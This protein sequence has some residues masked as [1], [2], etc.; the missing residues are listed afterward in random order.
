MLELIKGAVGDAA[1]PLVFLV[2]FLAIGGG[3]L[4]ITPRLARWLDERD[5]KHKGYFDGMMTQSP[6]ENEEN[7]EEASE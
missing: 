5:K 2:L 6:E 3:A 4:W 1:A 7:T